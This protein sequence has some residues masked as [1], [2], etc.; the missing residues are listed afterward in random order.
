MPNDPNVTQQP[1]YGIDVS[2]MTDSQRLRL[3]ADWFDQEQKRRW[4]AGDVEV[5]SDLRRISDRLDSLPSAEPQAVQEVSP[6][7]GPWCSN[8]GGPAIHHA[9]G[10]IECPK[11]DNAAPLPARVD[12]DALQVMC[13]RIQ[14]N[15][16]DPQWAEMPVEELEA[17][18]AE[19]RESRKVP[20]W[21]VP[22]M[23]RVIIELQDQLAASRQRLAAL[24]LSGDGLRKENER[25]REILT[26]SEKIAI[27]NE[28]RKPW[29][30]ADIAAALNSP[31]ATE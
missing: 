24:E 22:A 3:L 8:C 21:A 2:R 16:G 18:L 10:Q 25:L 17:L 14:K 23:N 1:R 27:M 29:T 26:G 6:P 7:T 31:A 20:A 4:N 30:D 11:C 15:G 19:V 13:D 9:S 5:Q 28:L 12:I